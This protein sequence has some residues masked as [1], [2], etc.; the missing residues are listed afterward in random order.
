MMKK[1]SGEL[2]RGFTLVE[3]LVVI[4]II[5]I[6]VGLLLPAVQAAREAARRMQ[7]TNNLKQLGLAAHNFESATK[8]FP[9][10]YLGNNR[11]GAA[12]LPQQ[13]WGTNSGV[14]HLTY[15]LPYM[16]QQAIYQL[17]E[18][19]KDLNVDRDGVGVA[20][21]LASRYDIVWS[22]NNAWTAGNYRIGSLLCPSDDA[23]G[24][25]RHTALL[26][27]SW[28]VSGIAGAPA[29]SLWFEGTPNASWHLT[30]G[31]TN[32]M[33]CAGRRGRTGTTALTAATDPIPNVTFDTLKGIFYQRSKTKMAEI[34]DGTSNTIM[35]G[36]VTGEFDNHCRSI[37]RHTS[38]WFLTAS[39]MMTH[40]MQG[41][42]TSGIPWQ[43]S[44]ACKA[45]WR[46]SSFHSGGIINTTFADGSVRG[47]PLTTEY[48]VWLAAGGMADGQ[49][50]E[51]PE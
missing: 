32:Y 17:V 11:I 16:E 39:G 5:G 23:Y 1:S 9:P 38:F 8:R 25:T 12:G 2:H 10:G 36:E 31:K 44:V 6:L 24:G 50:F 14:G 22:T 30:M 33:G 3:L 21:A 46:Y 27:H 18:T 20:T 43:T 29:T 34:L 28:A 49:L 37:G 41:I 26:L 4:A 47:F 40:W 48:R 7:C 42:P 51:G 19:D 45:W 15:M 13:A 35:F